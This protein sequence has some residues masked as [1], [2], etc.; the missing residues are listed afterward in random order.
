[1]E[2]SESLICS[3][4]LEASALDSKG[5]EDLKPS[6]SAKST[7]IAGEYL[8]SIGRM[9]QSLRTS[10]S[11]TAEMFPELTLSAGDSHAKTYRLLDDER[12]WATLDLDYGQS[13]PAWLASY[14]RAT[15]SWRTRQ[16]CLVSGWQMFSETWPRSGMTRSGI[17]YQLAT[18][19]PITSEIA[20]GLLP[21]LMTG[22]TSMSGG[23]QNHR[24]KW[25]KMLPTLCARDYRGGATVERTVKM[26]E[27]SARGLDLPSMLRQL[28]PD[29][30]AAINPSWAEGYM[31]YEI[32]WTELELLETPSSRKSP[33]SS[34]K[35]SSRQKR[36]TE[37][38]S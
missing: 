35:R 31:G 28:F 25:N 30:T 21:T 26:R 4:E 22:N 8:E 24:I 12:G 15:S 17:A 33:K 20:S 9:S 34:A 10:T 11:S 6:P 29:S 19:A 27:E 36:A 23:P 2:N 14:D 37:A 5:P 38:K 7:P 18:L 1:M 3:A 32:G 13:T 16:A